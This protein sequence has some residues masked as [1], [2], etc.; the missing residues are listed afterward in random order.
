MEQ[1]A[2]RFRFFS[3]LCVQSRA[4]EA[5]RSITNHVNDTEVFAPHERHKI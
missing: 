3:Y 5:L 2:R 4:K 1:G